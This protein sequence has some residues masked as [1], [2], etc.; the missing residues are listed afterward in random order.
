VLFP[1]YIVIDSA[2]IGISIKDILALSNKKDS[3][4]S[5]KS[6]YDLE[7]V[8]PY[9]CQFDKGS[10]LFNWVSENHE[11]RDKLI[12]LYS[13]APFEVL[14]AHLK[15]FIIV[16]ASEEQ[17]Y[18]R[19]Y[20]PQVIQIFLPTCTS[21]QLRIFFGPVQF[22]YCCEENEIK[23]YSLRNLTLMETV[24]EL[25]NLISG[26]GFIESE[27]KEIGLTEPSEGLSQTEKQ[28]NVSAPPPQIV[29]NKNNWKKF[30]FND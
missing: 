9:L 28:T 11:N 26:I 21:E 18:F 19:F 15:K 27:G 8:A 5:G 14:L 13:A 12:F 4:F 6:K 20:D 25:D 3:L 17:F 10:K 2:R 7:F 16:T 22:F 29:D 30:F 23:G 24:Y 1:N